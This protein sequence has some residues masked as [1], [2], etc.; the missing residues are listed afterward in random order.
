MT[1]YSHITEVEIIALLEED[2][3]KLGGALRRVR[4]LIARSAGQTHARWQLLDAAAEGDET[5][6]QLA[7]RMG[8]A[9]Q[10]V[11]RVADDLVGAG[12]I[13]FMDNPDH[14]RAPLVELTRSGKRV[15]GRLTRRAR[16]FRELVAKKTTKRSLGGLQEA[17]REVTEVVL[18]VE[19]SRIVAR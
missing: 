12:L 16:R 6:S 1:A 11:Q 14:R 10:S 5:V 13:A 2:I 3:F 8:L 18:R 9:R 17:V 15:L 7:R 4:Q 19:Q